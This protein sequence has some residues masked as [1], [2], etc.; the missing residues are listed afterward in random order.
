M[1]IGDVSGGYSCV[2]L[3]SAKSTGLK[4][5]NADRGLSIA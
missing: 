3:R 2:K 5:T 1:I 4:V